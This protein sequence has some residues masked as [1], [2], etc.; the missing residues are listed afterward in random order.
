M[1]AD[2]LQYLKP[3]IYLLHTATSCLSPIKLWRQ[4]KNKLICR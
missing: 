2:L 4:R 1:G 3:D